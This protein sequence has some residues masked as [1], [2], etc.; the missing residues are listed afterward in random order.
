MNVL[1]EDYK[2]PYYSGSVGC[3]INLSF[4]YIYKSNLRFGVSEDDPAVQNLLDDAV[5]FRRDLSGESVRHVSAPPGSILLV[6]AWNQSFFYWFLS[7][8][9]LRIGLFSY[10]RFV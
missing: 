3:I 10:F 8:P 4:I 6:R 9:L 5:N 2:D 7:H 1:R